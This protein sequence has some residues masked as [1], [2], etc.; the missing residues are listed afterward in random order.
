MKRKILDKLKDLDSSIKFSFKIYLMKSIFL[1][2]NITTND[3]LI[4]FY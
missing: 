4:D 3:I 1:I 2:E